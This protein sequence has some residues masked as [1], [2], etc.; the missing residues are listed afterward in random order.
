MEIFLWSEQIN[1]DW[2]WLI[3]FRAKDPP[4]PLISYHWLHHRDDIIAP[5]EVPTWEV[6]SP[7]PTKA[8]GCVSICVYLCANTEPFRTFDVWT[9]LYGIYSRVRPFSYFNFYI[10]SAGHIA[11]WCVSVSRKIC[12]GWVYVCSSCGEVYTD[13]WWHYC[14]FS[15]RGVHNSRWL[16]PTSFQVV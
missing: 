16:F 8:T 14:L 9:L 13:I 6:C 11:G 7:S 1:D 3:E 12:Q 4:S 2:S 15:C 10:I 5:R